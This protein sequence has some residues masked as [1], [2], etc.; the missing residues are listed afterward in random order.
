MSTAAAVYSFADAE[1]APMALAE[2]ANGDDAAPGAEE[3][4]AE[5]PE[6][7]SRQPSL[8]DVPLRTNL[9]ETAFFFPHLVAGEDGTVTMEFTMPEA[10]TS[11][12][13][14]A[15][16]HDEELRSGYLEDV[17]VTAKD[18]MVQ[19]NP[20][21]FLR[22][23]DELEFPVKIT[24]QGEGPQSGVVRLTFRNARTL[25]PASS[26]LG[27]D[28]VEQEF[29]VPAG[30]SRVFTWRVEVPDG[31]EFLVYRAVA[32]SGTLSD[33]EEG[34]LPVLPRRILVTESISLPI[35][36][37][38]EKSFRL[39]KLIESGASNTLRHESLTVQ[40]VS[41]PNWYAVM[42]LPYLMEFPHEC[43][44]Q[45]FGRYY[46][47]TLAQHIAGSDPAIRRV[48]NQWKQS[49]DGALESPLEQNEELKSVI[50]E[51]TPWVRDAASETAARR[52]VGI[53]FDENRLR[54]EQNRALRKLGEQQLGNGAWPWFTGGGP[55]EFITLYIVTGMGRLRHLGVPEVDVSPA[56]KALAWLDGRVAERYRR[57]VDE[58]TEEENHLSPWIAYYL[59][60]RS[61][62]LQDRALSEPDRNAVDYFLGQAREH[63]LE[64]GNRQSQA[65]VALG[66][67]RFGD[68]GETPSDIVASL[69]ERAVTDEELGMYWK[70]DGPGY[71]WHRAP[72][73]TQAFLI[74][75]FEEVAGDESAVE[76]LKVWL[77]KQKQTQ[78][79][80]T[81]KATAEAVYALLLRGVDPLTSTDLVKVSLGGTTVKPDAVEA[82]TGFFETRFGS[83][84]IEPELGKATLLK[85]SPGV[86]WGSL[87][88]QYL[89]SI[90]EIT[91]H[92]DNPLTVR[93]A[94]F[95]KEDSDE[96]PVLHRL[97]GGDGIEVGDRIVVRLEIRS[98][99]DMEFLHLEDQR[100]SGLEP[101]NVL[102]GY[103][104]QDAL[105]YYESTRDTASHF[106]IDALGA[107]T[108]VFEYE[109]RA[110]HRG[111]YAGGL[112]RL[113]CMY[114]PEFNSHSES[115]R[116]QVK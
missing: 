95:R 76:E 99:R 86:A 21:R 50:L 83:Q 42:A 48:F 2:Q 19:P 25:E 74:E 102:S 60:G 22:E 68:P 79:W 39:E 28:T 47:N 9:E 92:E 6:D 13:F 20:P 31:Q 54:E 62:F 52:R 101:V 96:G 85:R 26:A 84:E 29:S 90:G 116:L 61:F 33:G 109:L 114:A 41:H 14:L 70:E 32:S 37:E 94:L 73:E 24:N 56:L 16:A 111:E 12:R 49:E 93:K 51:E 43:S 34:Y 5:G 100:G 75:L 98:D 69:R 23:G 103:R 38:G 72:I 55:S 45:V 65:Q 91:P 110:V 87:H 8:D 36:G 44:E 7:A 64:L 35:R 46:A 97:E 82:G 4:E 80:E 27:I 66:L 89:E 105:G 104:Y 88:W 57:I 77:L 112:A 71:R 40:M 3:T 11:W 115:V 63:W 17:T 30:E 107:G 106:F 81:T 15:F 108:Y 58:K 18:L 59:Y 67:Q 78:D 10:L 1:A 113:Q 53:L